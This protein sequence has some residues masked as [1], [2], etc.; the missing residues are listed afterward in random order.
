MPRQPETGGAP[1]QLAR[2]DAPLF[3]PNGERR[4]GFDNLV[5][6]TGLSHPQLAKDTAHEL[7]QLVDPSH[8]IPVVEPVTKF[9]EGGERRVVIEPNVRGRD[10]MIIQSL[11]LNKETE[12]NVN[13]AWAEVLLMM[14][15][16]I[17]ASVGRIY[18]V[19]PYYGYG[20]QD[21]RSFSR[22]PISA[23]AV[24][25]HIEF[26]AGGRFGGIT[27]VDLHAQQIQGS[28]N[29]PWD[30]LY[31]EHVLVPAIASGVPRPMT[32]VSPDAGGG[33][34]ADRV[35]RRLD[36]TA[37]SAYKTRDPKHPDKTVTSALMG[38]V[39]GTHAVIVDD[40][41]AGGGSLAD[42][43]KIAIDHGAIDVYAAV[44]H[45]QMYGQADQKLTNSPIVRLFTTDT[46]P[47]RP[48]EKKTVL[49]VAHM[50]AQAIYCSLTG[51]S[52]HETLLDN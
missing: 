28:I 6:M 1:I 24:A 40:V 15:A 33:K 18:V 44:T 14:D 50:L 29:S 47:Q 36:A 35:A 30:D 49:P 52:I 8:T 25:Q 48:H 3:T 17:R 16:L 13:D 9:D 5:I 32:I 26:G 19:I 20:R 39:E 38:D 22:E 43:A 10:V 45:A 27:T 46:I 23:A 42:A 11:C 34:R 31:G 51:E 2:V 21:R 7:S 4:N 12:T 37:A 41:I